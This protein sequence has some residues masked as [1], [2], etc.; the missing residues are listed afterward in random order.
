ML[1]VELYVDSAD[2][3]LAGP[4]GTLV[5]DAAAACPA[6]DA[7]LLVMAST[8]VMTGTA[9]GTMSTHTETMSS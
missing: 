5:T 2:T 3:H 7:Q 1:R 9:V 8:P 6:V 4:Q